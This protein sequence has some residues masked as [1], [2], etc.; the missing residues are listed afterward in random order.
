MNR[1]M[2]KVLKNILI[3]IVIV[4]VGVSLSFIALTYVLG[5]EYD[6]IIVEMLFS[7]VLLF[8]IILYILYILRKLKGKNDVIDSDSENVS[9]PSP[10]PSPSVTEF[11]TDKQLSENKS[12]NSS[13]STTIT[14]TNHDGY[15][16]IVKSF[17]LLLRKFK[18]DTKKFNNLVREKTIFMAKYSD[19][20]SHEEYLTNK[21]HLKF[22]SNESVLS[23]SP[24]TE[25]ANSDEIKYSIL[26][27]K[28]DEQ[29]EKHKNGSDKYNK[30][31]ETKDEFIKNY[32]NGSFDAFFVSNIMLYLKYTDKH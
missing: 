3:L 16:E 4:T 6:T 10:S 18:M 24:V 28:F 31:L 25:K 27:D 13:D 20:L 2:G 26:I 7:I 9:S 8:M 23:P 29:L 14:H 15:V 19:S 1:V 30:L 11:E 22:L 17:N 5:S 32:K 12:E 21:Y